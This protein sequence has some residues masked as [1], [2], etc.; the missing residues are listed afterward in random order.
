MDPWAETGLNVCGQ[1]DKSMFLY[2]WFC[3]TSI[4]TG[5]WCPVGCRAR[6]GWRFCLTKTS[7]K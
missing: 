7:I 1:T 6:L 3:E 5:A 2:F 4:D